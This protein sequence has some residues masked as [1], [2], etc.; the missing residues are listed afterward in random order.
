MLHYNVQSRMEQTQHLQIILTKF[1]LT[2]VPF[3]KPLTATGIVR[4]V[5]GIVIISS[6]KSIVMSL[7]IKEGINETFETHQLPKLCVDIMRGRWSSNFKRA[8]RP[9][10][11]L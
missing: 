9:D 8:S 10:S 4:N 7:V 6:P 1:V 11:Y 2:I 3:L 5:K